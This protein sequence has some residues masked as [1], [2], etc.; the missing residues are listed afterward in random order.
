M[1]FAVLELWSTGRLRMSVHA[2]FPLAEAARAH[3]TLEGRENLGRV[4][5]TVEAET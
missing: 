4:V 1:S 3:P 5:L 2:T